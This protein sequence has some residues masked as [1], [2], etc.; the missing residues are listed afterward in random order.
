MWEPESGKDSNL[1]NSSLSP[2]GWISPVISPVIS[3]SI[4]SPNNLVINFESI[5]GLVQLKSKS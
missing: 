4:L 5:L 3:L 1:F 2:Y